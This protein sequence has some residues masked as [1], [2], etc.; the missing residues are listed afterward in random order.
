MSRIGEFEFIA[1][2]LAPLAA[3][4]E[5]AFGLT[6][7]AAFLAAST[8]L[9]V[10]SDTL[11]QGVHFRSDD[12]WDVAA[13]KA[14]RMNVS[15]LVAMAARPHAFLLSIVWPETVSARDQQRFVDGLAEDSAGYG[16]PLIGGDTTRGGDCLVITI[17]ALGEV[18][19]PLRRSGAQPGDRVFVTG[20][21][22]DGWLGL[23]SHALGLP[24][25]ERNSLN[26][27]YLLPQP[28]VAL[29]ETLRTSATAGLDVSDGLI[30]DAG[31]MAKASGVSVDLELANIP[32]SAAARDWLARQDKRTDAMISLI[33]GGDDYEM[34]FCCP[35]D[36]VEA[37]RISA[38]NAGVAVTDIGCISEGSGVSVRDEKGNIVQIL[39]T[40]FTHF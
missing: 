35:A 12:P 13:R 19:Q 27:R 8:G 16:M 23:Q 6:D 9:V 2:S 30:S 22:G 17:T 18:A 32:L 36:R 33:T 39:K 28:P 1:Q 14:L 26:D 10:T 4:Y 38:R 25:T 15:D 40:G 29:I 11:I 24:E 3:D 7:D 31:H 21:I 34:L 37:L 20:T 5:G